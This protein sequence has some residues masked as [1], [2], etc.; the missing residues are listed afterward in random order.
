MK[1]VTKFCDLTSKSAVNPIKHNPYTTAQVESW[2]TL[3][4]PVTKLTF[5]IRE[6]RFRD[7]SAKSFTITIPDPPPEITIPAGNKALRLIF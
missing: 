5:A 1:V 7:I 2:T 4:D 3:F 6:G